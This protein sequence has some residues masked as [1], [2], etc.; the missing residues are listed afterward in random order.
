KWFKFAKRKSDK[1]GGC[2][3]GSQL[4]EHVAKRVASTTSSGSTTT[5][6]STSTTGTVPVSPISQMLKKAHEE[7]RSTGM[8]EKATAEEL[9]YLLSYV[10][11]RSIA[12]RRAIDFNRQMQNLP[13]GHAMVVADFKANIQLGKAQVDTDDVFFNAPEASVFCLVVA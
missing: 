13:I 7:L 3:Y 9:T 4:A 5:S 11:H 8:Q 12:R 2:F 6:Y 1:C 10:Q